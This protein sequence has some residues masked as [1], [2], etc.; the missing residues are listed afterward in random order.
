[1]YSLNSLSKWTFIAVLIDLGVLPVIAAESVDAFP[2]KAV[3]IVVPQAAGGGINRRRRLR[4]SIPPAFMG[5][6]CGVEVVADFSP[7]GKMSVHE[8][9]EAVVVVPFVE[10]DQARN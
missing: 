2:N 7:V 3:R 1:M 9:D 5:K 10:V 6:G 8:R 4:D